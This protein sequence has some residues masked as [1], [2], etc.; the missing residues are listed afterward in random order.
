MTKEA[1]AKLDKL[2]DQYAERAVFWFRQ[3][4]MMPPEESMEFFR[5]RLEIVGPDK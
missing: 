1:I 5:K 4:K 2:A 3:L